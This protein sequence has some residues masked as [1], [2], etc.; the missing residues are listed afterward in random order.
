MNDL[1][2]SVFYVFPLFACVIL[3]LSIDPAV[4]DDCFPDVSCWGIEG[5]VHGFTGWGFVLFAL[6]AGA[7]VYGLFMA[8]W[9]LFVGP[10]ILA[11]AVCAELVRWYRV[12]RRGW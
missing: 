7:L 9:I 4:A 10:F 3:V 5:P 12:C 11:W 6:L 8:G 2:H 1:N